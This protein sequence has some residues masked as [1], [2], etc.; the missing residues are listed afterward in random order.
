[1]TE[2]RRTTISHLGTRARGGSTRRA[3]EQSLF[4]RDE[5]RRL[6]ARPFPHH[7]RRVSPRARRIT[8]ITR[9]A[10]YLPRARPFTLSL[11]A[12]ELGPAPRRWALRPP[13][14]AL[15]FGVA[16]NAHSCAETRH[17]TSELASN[18]PA[19][20]PGLSLAPA[21]DELADEPSGSDLGT[22]S[23][24]RSRCR[25]MNSGSDSPSGQRL[26]HGLRRNQLKSRSEATRKQ[27]STTSAP[28]PCWADPD[29]QHIDLINT[30]SAGAGQDDSPLC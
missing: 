12:R 7:S 5:K 6:R 3:R 11:R 2:N 29:L 14:P 26:G 18:H 16:C 27:A 24:D 1:M 23:P 9:A 25:Q 28:C 4:A 30:N 15:D 19:G 17:S 21:S 8:R 13:G 10:S 20:T 22:T